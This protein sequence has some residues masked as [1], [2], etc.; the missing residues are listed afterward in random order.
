MD[1]S[2]LQLIPANV[3]V[4]IAST[5]IF[6]AKFVE[7]LDPAAPSSE[8]LSAEQTLDA[9]HVTVEINTI[10]QRLTSVLAKIEPEKLNETLGAMSSAFNGRG[11]RFGETLDDLN[12][13]L[14]TLDPSLPSLS[15]D[16]AAAPELSSAYADAASDLVKVVDNA[17]RVSTSIVDEQHNL[18]AFLVGMIGLADVGNDVLGSN[19]QALTDVLH[20]LVPTTDLA[21][22]YREALY[23]TI[24]GLVP[25]ALSPPMPV[26]AVVVS[27]N[28]TAGVERYRYPQDLP[29]VAATGGP[30]CKDMG[31]P[32][33]PFESR[34]PF[35][36]ADV[37]SNP[38]RYGNQGVLLNS[39]GLKQF[40]FGPIDGPPRNTAQ[41]GQPG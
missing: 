13:Y 16:L 12:S 11:N 29:K 22:R 37:G 39:D 3:A 23:C 25:L 30:H 17:G 10:F 1:K 20:L 28:F 36:V 14:A 24:A 34:P 19:Q 9:D 26:P 5:T 6:G 41:F 4:N 35:L 18:D 32:N 15:H 7:F 38:W 2:Q 31:L 21:D 40:L 33:I 27:V 8:S